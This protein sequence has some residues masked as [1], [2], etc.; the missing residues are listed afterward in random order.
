MDLLNINQSNEVVIT[1]KEITD[2][3]EVRHNDSMKKVEALSN[4]PSFGTLRKT[5]ISH[6]KG[7]EI[8]TYLLNKKQAIAVG[9]KLNNALLMNLIDKLEEL[10][11]QKLPSSPMEILE[12]TFQS[13]KS[14]DNRVEI[15]EK[16]KRL[17]KW[18]EKEIKHAV[19]VKVYSLI[20]QNNLDTPLSKM[21]SRTWKLVK[22]KFQVSSYTSINAVDF[23][24]ALEFV[25]SLTINDYI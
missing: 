9:A 8:E 13:I 7:K 5:R 22:D 10:S 14:I 6:I 25:N 2:I 4:E 24:S 23:D 21:F 1:L 16:T 3:L 17:E 12:L 19:N 18:Q 11:K 15:L 20:A